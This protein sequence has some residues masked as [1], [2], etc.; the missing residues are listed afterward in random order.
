MLETMP[1]AP[2]PHL[3]SELC[4]RTIRGLYPGQ[5]KKAQKS[6]FAWSFKCYRDDEYEGIAVELEENV[7]QSGVEPPIYACKF[8][9]G[10]NYGHILVL[11]N[12][13][14]QIGLRDTRLVGSVSP[15]EGQQI[16]QNAIFDVCWVP[17]SAELVSVSGDQC[18]SILAVREDGTLDVTLSLL[19]H[20]RSVKTVHVNPYDPCVI[21]TGARDGSVIIWDK[22]CKPH[23]KADE[24]APA[25]S[26]LGKTIASP[27]VRKAAMASSSL[28]NSVTGVVFQQQHVVISS[29]ASDGLIKLWDLRK[30]HGGGKREPQCQNILEHTGRSSHRGFTSLSVSPSRDV[31]YTSCMD[32][33][34][35]AY[36]LANP[37]PKPVAEYTGHVNLTYFVKS[38]ISPCGSYL[39][40]GSSDNC[41]YIWLTDS[42]GQP[43]ARLGGHFAEVTSVG[44][45]PVDDEKVVTCAD[46]MKLRIFRRKNVDLDDFD[47]KINIRGISEPY[48]IKE[49]NS[50]CATDNK[51]AIYL[52]NKER[53]VSESHEPLPSL[54][55]TPST[56]R[57]RA[58]LAATPNTRKREG[59]CNADSP[60]THPS[61]PRQ[62]TP[63][64]KQGTKGRATPC[65][66]KTS[67][68][69]TLLTWLA[70]AKTPGSQDSASTSGITVV[71]DSKKAS[72]KRK[73]TDIIGE[74]QENI[75]DEVKPKSPNSPKK[76]IL[77]ILPS[78]NNSLSPQPS[79][80]KMLKYGD[81]VG[82][83]IL[84]KCKE[85]GEGVT[86]MTE[87]MKPIEALGVGFR[88]PVTNVA[89]KLMEKSGHYIE[90]KE[91]LHKDS[92]LTQLPE[93][94][95]NV[96]TSFSKTSFRI[97]NL[98]S[99]TANLPNYIVDGL[100]P[101][102]RPETR[103]QKKR[104][105]DWL[106]SFSHQRKLKFTRT[107]D[108]VIRNIVPSGSSGPHKQKDRKI[109]KI[110]QK[111]SAAP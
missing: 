32:N 38:C 26:N 76:S 67:D 95:I 25:H 13:D 34:I 77:G 58:S 54:P 2:R 56:S 49:R 92:T 65:T 50:E 48:I 80:A 30:T 64:R 19:G 15:V 86:E 98:S 62:Q 108:K 29:G 90:S 71:S 24:I 84:Q 18:V 41:A 103:V 79:V 9:E 53:T 44:W 14:G 94:Y 10:K 87:C 68:R 105:T 60:Q 5:V 27:S 104:N 101:H 99:P 111:K 12:E 21:A 7:P 43:I 85:K 1:G 20:T 8:G 72:L 59:Q 69:N 82:S 63:R 55:V 47:E 46:D 100:S 61:T 88:K 4:D 78:V 74:D 45:C 33:T 109:L 66:P 89:S 28:N 52:G 40:S 22:R 106:T 36:H 39:L 16:H 23:H 93:P 73:L 83:S 3:V 81:D 11:A 31:L 91:N 42:P 37:T 35:Y 17:G 107:P 51:T 57:T 97:G 102:N 75:Q 96:Q 110:K 70:T 6:L